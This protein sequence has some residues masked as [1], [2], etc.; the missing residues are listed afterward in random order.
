MM[1]WKSISELVEKLLGVSAGLEVNWS[2]FVY[3]MEAYLWFH[4]FGK[5][6]AKTAENAS[7]NI[8]RK[9]QTKYNLLI[10]VF[11]TM[12]RLKSIR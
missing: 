6:P 3:R 4:T 8:M 5:D 12:A 2:Q 9:T 1:T 11:L 7:K 10:E